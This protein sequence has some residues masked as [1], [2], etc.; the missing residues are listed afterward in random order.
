MKV[1][2]LKTILIILSFLT[3]NS[4]VYAG[5]YEEGCKYFS[6]KNYEK[7]REL[8]EKSIELTNDGNSY[9]FMGEM[10]KNEGNF[11]KAEEYYRTAVTKK[12]TP[13]YKKLAYWNLIVIEEQRGKYNEMVVLCRDLWEALKDE[14]AQK[15][16]DL[17]IN[18]L[19]WTNN[20]EAKALYMEGIEY[21]KKNN[22]DQAREAFYNAL[23]I[24]SGFL[25][26]KFEI[27]LF[28]YNEDNKSQAISYFNEIIDK[29]PFYG[30]VHLLLGDMYFNDQSYR[31]SAEHLD[32]AF[33]YGFFDNSTKYSILMKAGAAHYE[34]GELDM[35]LEKYQRATELNKKGIEPLLMLS[36]IYIKKDN[37]DQAIPVLLKAK[38]LKPN[39]SDIIF[40]I[41]SLYYKM[42]DQKYVQYFAQLFNQYNSVKEN[43]SQKYLKAFSILLKNYYDNKSYKEAAM[44]LD[45]LPETPDNYDTNLM[46]AKIY[47]NTGKFEKA[48][49]Y[50]EKLSLTDDDRFLLSISYAKTG[51]DNKAKNILT[52][53]MVLNG[54]TEK[55]K[56][57]SSTRKIAVEIENDKLEKEE[58][59]KKAAAEEKRKLE[60]E[61][62]NKE[63]EV[64]QEETLKTGQ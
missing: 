28:Y 39:N 43:M 17:L 19:L 34:L 15:K 63:I 58:A 57:E 22:R 31:Y 60:E 54:Y 47:F 21:K 64:Q 51:M 5:Y 25:A 50:F 30:A 2:Y 46:I 62:H 7:A 32:K 44:V 16:A 11:D 48:V 12:M 36:A 8:F 27:G 53:L 38:E 14:G 55:A 6:Y 41:G 59:I 45:R 40:Q 20:D 56:S 1:S 4:I 9:Y 61:K 18:K 29:I 37:Y 33:E 10:D 35:A 49:N 3:F 52:N 13:K 23:R 26:P 24:D 42:N